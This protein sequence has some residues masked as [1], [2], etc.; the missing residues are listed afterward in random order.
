MEPPA[1][2][3]RPAPSS[4]RADHPPPHTPRSRSLRRRRI[5]V[6]RVEA[7]LVINLP[8]LLVAQ[9]IVGFRDLLELLLRLLVPR[10]HVRVILA[11]S[12]A[13]LLA[14][15]VR[16]RRLL[17]TQCAVV[18]LCLCRHSLLPFCNQRGSC[19]PLNLTQ[20]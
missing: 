16:G 7:K 5:D 17:Y 3:A 1:P 13:K 11:R 9:N 19:A 6:V 8:L 10:I 12:L 14:N 2:H 15:L 20:S 4:S 18:I